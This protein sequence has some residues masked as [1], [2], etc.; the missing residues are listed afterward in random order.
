MTSEEGTPSGA[1]A[2]VKR[3]NSLSNADSLP[4]P[5]GTSKRSLALAVSATLHSVPGS[6]KLQP[7]RVI[8]NERRR[9]TRAVYTMGGV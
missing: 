1:R 2:P 8:Q 4:H 7:S 5:S 6:Q 9:R 3:S